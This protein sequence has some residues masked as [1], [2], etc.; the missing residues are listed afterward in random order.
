MFSSAA[1]YVRLTCRKR[2]YDFCHE[3]GVWPQ[4]GGRMK[5]VTPFCLV[6]SIAGMYKCKSWLSSNRTIGLSFEGLA[7]AMKCF[8]SYKMIL[9][10]LPG[11]MDR[12]L[13]VLNVPCSTTVLVRC[14]LRQPL[15]PCCSILPKYE[16]ESENPSPRSLLT[17][18]FA[19]LSYLVALRVPPT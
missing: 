7:C 1:T 6:Y 17:Y 4:C 5:T 19:Q 2:S 9:R 13:N 18:V 8:T 10:H 3:A 12:V 15:V 14:F 16:K 11:W